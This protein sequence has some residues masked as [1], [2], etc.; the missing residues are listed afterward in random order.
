[1]YGEV[2]KVILKLALQLPNKVSGT[3][4]AHIARGDFRIH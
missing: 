3:A 4:R 1:M 2:H